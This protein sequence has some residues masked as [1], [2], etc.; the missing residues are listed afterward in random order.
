MNIVALGSPAAGKTTLAKYLTTLGYTPIIPGALYRTAYEQRTE[1]GLKAYAYWGDGNI[2]PDEMT[3]E[4]MRQTIASDTGNQLVFDGYPR[5]LN[6]AQYLDSLVAID[7]VIDLL[8]S[9]DVAVDRLMRRREKE[10]RIDDTEKII[11]Q[12]L[13]VY[14]SNNGPIVEYYLSDLGRYKLVDANRPKDVVLAEIGELICSGGLGAS[15]SQ[16]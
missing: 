10:G 3:N 16:H 4:L 2:C 13:K 5:T 8:I 11:R 9:D 14:R 15:I 6:Q 7:M 12:R 1:F